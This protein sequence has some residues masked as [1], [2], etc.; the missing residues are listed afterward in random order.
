L[1]PG[2][3]VGVMEKSQ[4]LIKGLIEANPAPPAPQWIDANTDKLSAS[5]VV[6]PQREEIDPTIKE[7]LIV[8]YYSRR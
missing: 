8:E 3:K 5:I 2:Q 7:A 6:L 1:K 4:K